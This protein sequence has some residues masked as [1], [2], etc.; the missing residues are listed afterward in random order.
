MPLV[1]RKKYPSEWIWI[2]D[3][4]LGLGLSLSLSLI[5]TFIVH[6]HFDIIYRQ[7]VWR[8]INWNYHTFLIKSILNWYFKCSVFI[9]LENLRA[10]RIQNQKW[11]QIFK[12]FIENLLEANEQEEQRREIRVQQRTK[13]GWQLSAL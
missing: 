12:F 11:W 6:S 7:L 4:G 3:E 1:Y 8:N 10:H 2:W 5:G 13:N 9:E